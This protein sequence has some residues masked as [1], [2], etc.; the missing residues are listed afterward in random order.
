MTN[1]IKNV[2]VIGAGK[3]G[4]GIAHVCAASGFN[5]KLVDISDEYYQ[6]L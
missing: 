4:V 1:V 5:I 3:M 6:K 2:G